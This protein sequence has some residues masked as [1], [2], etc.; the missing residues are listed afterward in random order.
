MDDDGWNLVKGARDYMD[1]VEINRS[2][3][4]SRLD[5][6][7]GHATTLPILKPH[8]KVKQRLHGRRLYNSVSMWRAIHRVS[9][10]ELARTVGVSR[11]TII[12]IEN[13]EHMPAVG[14]ALAIAEV[15]DTSVDDVFSL[16]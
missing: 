10:S 16:R 2:L 1:R 15:F 9:Q 14:V 3:A 8:K 13:N 11:R 6:S 4:E 5:G 7:A 12:G